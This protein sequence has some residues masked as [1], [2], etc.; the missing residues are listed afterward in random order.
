[1]IDQVSQIMLTTLSILGFFLIARKNKWG[2]IIS[3]FS[4]PFWFY[5]SIVHRQWGVIVNTSVFTIIFIYGTY[6][7]FCNKEKTNYEK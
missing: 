3:L 1:M 6:N 2:F 5:T 4:Q 7:W